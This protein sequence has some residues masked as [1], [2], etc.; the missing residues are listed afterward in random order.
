MG[1]DEMFEELA[2][3]LRYQYALEIWASVRKFR[4]NAYE[5]ERSHKR[6]FKHR[7]DKAYS[8]HRR[9]LWRK[10]AKAY[11]ARKK[12]LKSGGDK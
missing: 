9:K 12:A 2:G 3:G 11:R 10:Q 4:V 1:I 7:V 5:V 6:A 8:D